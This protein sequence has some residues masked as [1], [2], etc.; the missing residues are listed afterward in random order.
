MAGVHIPDGWRGAVQA[1]SE[2][3]MRLECSQR[4][5]AAQLCW[6]DGSV[7]ACE[8]TEFQTFQLFVP[9]TC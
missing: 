8:R 7:G 5:A 2:S 3:M 6:A 9:L 1:C 4:S